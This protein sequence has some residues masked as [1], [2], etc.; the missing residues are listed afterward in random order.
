[1]QNGE[2]KPLLPSRRRPNLIGTVPSQ[3]MGEG[4]SDKM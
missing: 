2:A 1:M 3:G 4:F